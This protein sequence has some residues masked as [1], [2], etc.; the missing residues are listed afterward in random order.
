MSVACSLE[1]QDCS[2]V[3]STSSL[4]ISVD[5][6]VNYEALQGK[7]YNFKNFIISPERDSIVDNVVEC[8]VGN[9]VK[10]TFP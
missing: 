10:T 4:K 3:N 7:E 6:D 2:N 8:S 1:S 5:W 9:A